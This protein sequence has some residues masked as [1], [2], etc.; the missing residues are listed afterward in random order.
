MFRTS[1]WPSSGEQDCLRL[2]VVFDF[3][4]EGEIRG[5]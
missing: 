3:T 5:N 4:K 1:L 2:R